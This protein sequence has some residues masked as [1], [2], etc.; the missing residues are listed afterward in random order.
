MRRV[1]LPAQIAATFARS[2]ANY[3]VAFELTEP[4]VERWTPLHWARAVFEDAPAAL[5][6]CIVFGWRRVLGLRLAPRPSDRHVLGWAISGGDLVEGS[7]ALTAQSGFLQAS[8]I[9]AVDATTVTWVTLVHYSGAAARPLWALARPIHRRTIPY[10][11]R[12]AGDALGQEAG[13]DEHAA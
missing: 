11:L 9:V 5:R 7:V 12:R 2:T 3:A 13:S 8:N 6:W 1:E 4:G 10:L